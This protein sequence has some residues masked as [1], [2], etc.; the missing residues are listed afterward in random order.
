MIHDW[1]PEITSGRLLAAT[2]I[3]P[4]ESANAA[5]GTDSTSATVARCATVCVA[6]RAGR[7]R[8]RRG[9]NPV[10]CGGRGRTDGGRNMVGVTS[11]PATRGG[12][13]TSRRTGPPRAGDRPCLPAGAVPPCV[14][15]V[16]NRRRVSAHRGRGTRGWPV[17]PPN[18]GQVDTR[19]TQPLGTRLTRYVVPHPTILFCKSWR[20]PAG[21]H[22]ALTP[23]R[24]SHTTACRR[25]HSACPVPLKLIRCQ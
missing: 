24:P 14:G 12:R 3:G 23:A 1:R 8:S 13:G 6:T 4:V 22:T 25:S 2:Y 7:R 15:W 5:V 17:L 9:N 19:I 16:A 18:G 21:S 10:R 20:T 11:R